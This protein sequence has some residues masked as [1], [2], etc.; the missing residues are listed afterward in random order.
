MTY[1]E[2]IARTRRIRKAYQDAQ[3][4]CDANTEI[5]Q[6]TILRFDNQIHRLNIEIRLLEGQKERHNNA[7]GK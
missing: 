2:E 6:R 5:G 1:D 4:S 7:K 3:K